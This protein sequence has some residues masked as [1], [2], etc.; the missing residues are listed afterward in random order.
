[1]MLSRI[2]ALY[3]VCCT[4]EYHIR[5]QMNSVAILF[6]A[7]K[8]WTFHILFLITKHGGCYN[9][10]RVFIQSVVLTDHSWQWFR[11]H[12]NPPH[13]RF[14]RYHFCY[15]TLCYRYNIYCFWPQDIDFCA[16]VH[17]DLYC[18]EDYTD[19]HLDSNAS[20]GAVCYTNWNRLATDW[21]YCFPH[22]LRDLHISVYICF[23]LTPSAGFWCH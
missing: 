17:Y 11:N 19:H 4:L 23:C 20:P 5:I 16:H 15:M 6:Q 2:Q 7:G 1:M 8:T 18:T 21:D 3:P 13:C 22:A 10:R 14:N 9:S 12:Q